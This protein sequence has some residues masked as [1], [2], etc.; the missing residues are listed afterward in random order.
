MNGEIKIIVA[1]LNPAYCLTG[2]E[3][4]EILRRKGRGCVEFTK[5]A[6]IVLNQVVRHF[7]AKW[8]KISS[9]GA[10]ENAERR[11]AF[12]EDLGALQ[13]DLRNY[14]G[15]LA[16]IAQVEDLSGLSFD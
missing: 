2:T 13:K 8:H 4:L 11:E 14:T 7:T 12:R 10:F 3:V 16:E 6:V 9:E 5:I 1:A 15:L